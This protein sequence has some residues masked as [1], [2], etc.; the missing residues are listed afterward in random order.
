MLVIIGAFAFLMYENLRPFYYDARLKVDVP[1][2][3]PVFGIDISHHQGEINFDQMFASDFSDSIDFFYIKATEGTN[4]KDRRYDINAEGIAVLAGKYGFYHFYQAK[5]SAIEQANHFANTID[6]YNYKLKPVLD[7]ESLSG[8]NE[9]VLC[10][11]LLVF[12]N[13]V[14]EL[15]AVRPIIYTFHSFYIDH[16][17]GH[18]IE[19]ELYWI[20]KYNGSTHLIH[21]DNFI[22]WQFSESGHLNGVNENI[23]LNVA[24]SSFHKKVIVKRD[25][26]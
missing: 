15:L 16:L 23:D 6:P 18:K 25:L 8:M 14:E 19:N 22:I 13:R 11:S 24:K 12:M 5:Q 21:D 1:K 4:H 3:Y 9:D 20:A 26:K 17:A 2:G 10:D 7:I